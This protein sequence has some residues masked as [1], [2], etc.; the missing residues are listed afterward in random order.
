MNLLA[1][2]NLWDERA[3]EEMLMIGTLELVGSAAA[4]CVGF[5]AVKLVLDKFR[6]V[7][8]KDP[9]SEQ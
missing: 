8:A 1:S 9:S 3:R 6:D 4:V 2:A 7:R 5:C